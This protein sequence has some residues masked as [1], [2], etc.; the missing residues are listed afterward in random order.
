M[1]S[2]TCSHYAGFSAGAG[3]G[4]G[5]PAV[6]AGTVE[7]AVGGREGAVA[8]VAGRESLKR[9]PRFRPRNSISWASGA[10]LFDPRWGFFFKRSGRDSYHASSSNSTKFSRAS[11][12]A[13]FFRRARSAFR[14]FF[15][16]S[17]AACFA[18]RLRSSRCL[19]KA[20]R[21]LSLSAS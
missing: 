2:L 6:A 16:F 5:A 1:C 11:F 4:A 10:T 12:F 15:F 21:A 14:L 19:R 7:G 3:A 9:K 18:A 13:A 8:A 20:F 17:M